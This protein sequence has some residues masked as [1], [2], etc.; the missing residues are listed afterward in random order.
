MKCVF[1][2]LALSCCLFGCVH[3][4]SEESRSLVD[5]SL[6]FSQLRSSPDTLVGKF[7]LLGGVIAGVRNGEEG[8]HLEVVHTPHRGDALPE[9]ISAASGGR[10]LAVS[11]TFLDPM[12]YQAGRRVTLVGSIAGRKVIPLDSVA[13]SYPIIAIKEIYVW[14][15]SETEPAYRSQP[16][17]YYDPF[18][19]SSPYRWY[20]RPYPW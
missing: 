9:E 17:Y 14:K 5:Q 16:G 7:V 19:W 10:F 3:V 4:I 18:W 2:L 20:R 8:A 13:Y 12:V 11:D 6:T 1:A 15:K